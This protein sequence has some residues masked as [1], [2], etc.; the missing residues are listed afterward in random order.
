MYSG[1]TFPYLVLVVGFFDYLRFGMSQS[2][3]TVDA[4]PSGLLDHLADDPQQS[5]AGAG[6]ARIDG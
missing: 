5:L 4:L 3:N 2:F 6:T 1:T